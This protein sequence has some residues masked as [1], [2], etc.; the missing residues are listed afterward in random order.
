M[1]KRKAAKRSAKKPTKRAAKK[2]KKP[3]KRRAPTAETPNTEH[4]HVKETFLPN[5]ASDAKRDAMAAWI[6]RSRNG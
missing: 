2:S 5:V 1:T 3:T 4:G 6:L